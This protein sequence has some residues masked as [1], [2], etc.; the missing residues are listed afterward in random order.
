MKNDKGMHYMLL[1]DKKKQW[2]SEQQKGLMKGE[3]LPVI[4]FSKGCIHND[5]S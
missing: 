1:S 5:T 4:C 3:V 2:Y